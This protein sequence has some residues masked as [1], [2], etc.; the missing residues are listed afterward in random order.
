MLVPEV[1]SSAGGTVDMCCS[2]LSYL[3]VDL[4][5]RAGPATSFTLA[6]VLLKRYNTARHKTQEVSGLK[7]VPCN[8]A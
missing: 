3:L 4:F 6:L 5:S 7:L 2:L 1:E 8:V